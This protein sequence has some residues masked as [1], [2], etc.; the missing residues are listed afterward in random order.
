MLKRLSCLFLPTDHI[1]KATIFAVN[2]PYSRMALCDSKTRTP[3]S[4]P[5]LLVLAGPSGTGKSTI[6][7]RLFAEYPNAFGFSVSHTTR[8]PRSNEEHGVHYYFTDTESMNREITEGKFIE[9]A[10]YS[11]NHY[12]TSI[13]AVMR[14]LDQ[15]K[16][17][18][19][20]ID[21]QGVQAIKNH[22]VLAARSFFIFI[23]APS[24][25]VLEERLRL[26]NSENDESMRQRMEIAKR[27]IAYAQLPGSYDR[28][29]VNDDLDRAYAEFKTVV[30]ESFQLRH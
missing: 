29:I 16:I 6:L 19:L 15:G 4:V 17:C 12:G 28:I 11:G 5:T 22:E 10:Y 25:A 27:E 18:I 21:M 23:T 1:R 9:H 8:E 20:D 26:R 2:L 3:P 30:L 24:S 7:K 13:Q 14:V